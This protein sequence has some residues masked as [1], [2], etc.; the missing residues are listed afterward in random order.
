VHLSSKLGKILH[1]FSFFGLPSAT[2]FNQFDLLLLLFRLLRKPFEIADYLHIPRFSIL[3]RCAPLCCG[4]G[5]LWQKKG[6]RGRQMGYKIR[7]G[8]AGAGA[9]GEVR[10]FSG[11]EEA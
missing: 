9:P 10:H 5:D 11:L 2:S 4:G 7:G 6:V 3:V 8:D 1:S